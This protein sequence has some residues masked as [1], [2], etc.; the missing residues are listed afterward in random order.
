MTA[1]D[2]VMIKR[3][4]FYT[5]VVLVVSAT[6]IATGTVSAQQVLLIALVVAFFTVLAKGAIEGIRLERLRREGRAPSP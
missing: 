2:P 4:L 5:L 1:T 6:A 3:I